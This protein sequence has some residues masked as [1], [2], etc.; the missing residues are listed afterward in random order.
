MDARSMGS[1]SAARAAVP[2]PTA[3]T[4]PVARTTAAQRRGRD[5]RA[6]PIGCPSEH[7][8][9][10]RDSAGWS[11]PPRKVAGVAEVQGV[12]YGRAATA[13]LHEA[14]RAA[15]IDDPLAPVTV[16]VPSNLAGLSA[17]RTLA[18]GGGIANVGFVTPFALA[19]RLGR[20]RSAAAGLAPITEPVLVAAIRVEL[21]TDP[22]FFGP[23]AEPAATE[24]ALARRYA[25][26][27]RARPATR[28]RIR[29]EGSARA[30]ALVGLFERVRARL[31]GYVD[32][33]DLVGH[34][35]D[36]VRED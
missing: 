6:L 35:L 23:V 7:V 15:Q 28:D 31:Q 14:I 8:T 30:Q 21:R 19:E 5:R 10:R 34:A 17:R 13:A 29:R 20:A 16:V 1:G 27:S 12:A 18:E 11:H 9:G 3:T 22:G 4:S 24:S 32:E 33:D 36:A 2:A 25:E 26:L